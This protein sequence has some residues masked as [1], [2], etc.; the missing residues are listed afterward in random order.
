MQKHRTA[1]R[2]LQHNCA[3]P[4]E[5]IPLQTHPTPALHLQGGRWQGGEAPAGGQRQAAATARRRRAAGGGRAVGRGEVPCSAVCSLRPGGQKCGI[6]RKS[7]THAVRRLWPA[8]LRR[9]LCMRS[10]CEQH[11]C[12]T[13]AVRVGRVWTHLMSMWHHLC[14]GPQMSE[15]SSNVPCAI[16][17]TWGCGAWQTRCTIS[18]TWCL[19]THDEKRGLPL[20]GIHGR[21][22]EEGWKVDAGLPPQL[23]TGTRLTPIPSFVATPF[24][25]SRP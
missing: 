13:D 7:T 20:P 17:R 8:V 19:P 18:F 9:L 11:F 24:C 2:S 15:R 14:H 4:H 6:F 5:L 22:T 23:T 3:N 16:R 12:G 10:A 1:V 25:I 21:Q